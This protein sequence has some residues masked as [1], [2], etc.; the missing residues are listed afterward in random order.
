MAAK[1]ETLLT[2]TKLSVIKDKIAYILTLE[3]AKQLELAE[4]AED[5]T[6][7]KQLESFYNSDKDLNIVV[8]R[9]EQLDANE[10]NGICLNAIREENRHGTARRKQATTEF[11]ILLQGERNEERPDEDN[12]ETLERI[13]G[14][15][16]D[17]LDSGVYNDLD[18]EP[19]YIGN[20]LV[21]ERVFFFPESFD[22][23]TINTQA[24]K[25]TVEYDEFKLGE[26]PVALKGNRTN[27]GRY[28][29]KTDF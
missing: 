12:N 3:L 7:T 8:D 1:I 21:E 16:R 5:T 2:A 6:Y 18:L 15:I 25:F 11:A 20:S 13:S 29:I 23:Q 19:G 26:T 17:I 28:I 24:I 10:M 22:A 9:Y 14:V 27:T 4:A